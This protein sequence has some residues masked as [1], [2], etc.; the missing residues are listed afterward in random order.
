MPGGPRVGKV[1]E[2][3]FRCWLGTGRRG[4]ELVHNEGDES[5]LKMGVG[6]RVFSASHLDTYICLIQ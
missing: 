2:A 4:R 3:K 5:I 6:L 1:I